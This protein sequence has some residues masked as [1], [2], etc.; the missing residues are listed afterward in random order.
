MSEEITLGTDEKK[1][2]PSAWKLK[3]NTLKKKIGSKTKAKV[4]KNKINR[5]LCMLWLLTSC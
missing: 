4:Q 1:K 2:N 5:M 3:K